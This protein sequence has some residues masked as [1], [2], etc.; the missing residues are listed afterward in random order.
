MRKTNHRCGNLFEKGQPRPANAGR[1]AGVP[2]RTTQILKD[3]I[4]MAAELTGYDKKGKDELVGY[5]RFV[6]ENYPQSFCA[7]LGR[8]LPLQINARNESSVRGQYKTVE[9]TRAA[10][11]ERGIEPGMIAEVLGLDGSQSGRASSEANAA[12]ARPPNSVP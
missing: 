9:E 12:R 5:L 3:A 7:L 2:N 1:K 10:L 8:V 11:R 6:A 4:L